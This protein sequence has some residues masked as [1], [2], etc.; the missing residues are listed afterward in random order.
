M[1][2]D[3]DKIVSSATN[4]TVKLW[5]L[6]KG[7]FI[8]NLVSFPTFTSS[9]SVWHVDFNGNVIVVAYSREGAFLDVIERVP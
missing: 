6:Q 9:E 7:Q 3:N 8:R 5:D 2:V 4:M 1:Q